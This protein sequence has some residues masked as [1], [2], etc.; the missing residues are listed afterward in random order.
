MKKITL[1]GYK[2]RNFSFYCYEVA[3]PTGYL[4]LAHGVAEDALR[5]EY[6]ALALNE[7][8][9]NVYVINHIAHGRD[10]P[11]DQL[12]HWEKGDFDG[13]IENFHLMQEYAKK[14]NPG[15]KAILFGHS[16]GS[17]IVQKYELYHP[18]QFD[19]TILCGCAK[20]DGLYKFGKFVTSLFAFF[21]KPTKRLPIIDKISFGS[22]NKQFKPNKTPVDWLSKDEQNCQNYMNDPYCGAIGTASFYKEFYA[23]VSKIPNKQ[24]DHLYAANYPILLIGGSDD[25]VSNKAKKLILLAKYYQK[26]SQDVQYI[27]YKDDRHEILNEADKDQVIADVKKW[28]GEHL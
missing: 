27:I 13:C 15:K 3:D 21:N 20:A 1:P 16:M 24:Y 7:M 17:F 22:F 8:K 6:F 18:H 23:N 10:C 19:M 4:C 5:Y 2:K 12:G 25:M 14:Q 26:Q 28:I 9:L 11:I